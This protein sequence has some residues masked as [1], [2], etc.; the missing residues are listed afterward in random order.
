MPII[1]RR[2]RIAAAGLVLAGLSLSGCESQTTLPAPGPPE[3]ATVT[4]QPERVV[5]TTELPGRT[6][7]YLVAEIRP[8]VSGLLQKRLFVEGANVR[9]GDLLYQIDPTPY[10]AAYDQAKAALATAEANVVTAEANVALAEA[11]LPAIRARAERLKELAAVRAVGQQNYDDAAAALREAEANLQVRKAAVQANRTAVEVNR[12]TMESA[13]INLSYTPVR[14]PISGRIGKS[15][16]TVGAMVTAYQ[17]VP[18]AVIQQLDPI[19][20]D[21]TQAS[22]DLLRLRRSLETGNLKPG[23]ASQRKVRLLLEDGTSYTREGTLQFRDVTVDPTT[24][25]VTL[26]MVFPNPREVLLPGMFVRA[27]VEEGV[28]EQALLIPQQGV[29]RDPKGNP[30]ALV[31]DENNKVVQRA[32]ELDRAMGDR[33]LVAGGLDPGDRVIVEGSQNIRPGAPVRAVPFARPDAN[34]PQAAQGQ[35]SAQAR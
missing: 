19:Y 14:A 27:I 31:V 32:L 10:Q 4:V 21:V 24:G 15:N 22:A 16:I 5:L 2:N 9:Q 7:A 20:V 33:W 28:R 8:Q 17:P 3:V 11:G 26:R 23:G 1:H 12:A 35:P 6:A 34:A 25:S 29:A 30:I 13:R 18:L